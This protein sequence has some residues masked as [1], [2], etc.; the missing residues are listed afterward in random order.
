MTARDTLDNL[1]DDA[2]EALLDTD[3]ALG[4]GRCRGN[5]SAD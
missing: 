3:A 1:A 4:R 5:A 2:C